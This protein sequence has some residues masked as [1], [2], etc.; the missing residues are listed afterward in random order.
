MNIDINIKES[1]HGY[2]SCL[3]ASDWIQIISVFIAMVATIIS[4]A[5]V[6]LTRKQFKEESEERNKKY[7]PI[8]KIQ[9][10]N[11]VNGFP[12]QKWFIIKNDGFPAYSIKNVHWVGM[13]VTII[14]Y[15]RSNITKEKNNEI[16][17]NY[18]AFS[19]IIDIDIDLEFDGYFK[20]IGLDIDNNEFSFYSPRVEIENGEIKNDVDLTYQYLNRSISKKVDS[21]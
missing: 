11:G 5:T 9:E 16:T 2:W 4:L 13:G 18:E 15:Y 7:T 20:I 21:N 19:L 12:T 14:N 8:F 3:E 10:L 1:C 6:L 17:E